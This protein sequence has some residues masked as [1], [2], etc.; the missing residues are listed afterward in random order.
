MCRKRAETGGEETCATPV[1]ERAAVDSL[2]LAIFQARYLDVDATKARAEAQLDERIGVARAEAERAAGEALSAQQALDRA[3]R[4]R[5]EGE[6][7]ARAYSRQVEAQGAALE[8]A[9][10]EHERLAAQADQ[11]AAG[12]SSLDTESGVLRRLAELRDAMAERMAKRAAMC[13]P[14]GPPWPPSSSRRS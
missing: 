10:A 3:D 12:L 11:I 5:R 1:L 4:D 2:A 14:C 8:A 13:L 6:L 9:Q 7:G